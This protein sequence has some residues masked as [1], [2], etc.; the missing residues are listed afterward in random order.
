MDPDQAQLFDSDH[1]HLLITDANCLDP[2][3]VHQFVGFDLDLTV[4]CSGYSKCSK[5]LNVY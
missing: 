1:I 3:Q 2:D 5:I 4:C